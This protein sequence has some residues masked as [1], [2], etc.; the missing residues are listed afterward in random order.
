MAAEVF[1]GADVASLV[2]MDVRVK[3]INKLV[4]TVLLCYASCHQANIAESERDRASSA[5]LELESRR[6]NTPY[7]LVI[8]I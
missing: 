5:A 2:R 6:H 1:E 3:R 4:E 8:T 7:H